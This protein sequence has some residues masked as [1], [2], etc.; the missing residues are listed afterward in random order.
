MHFP[1][2]LLALLI[3]AASAFGQ[4]ARVIAADS[5]K[6]LPLDSLRADTTRPDTLHAKKQEGVD[7]LVNYSADE[8]DFGVQQRVT[9]LK[10]SAV[11]T[12]KDMRLEA[13]QITVDWNKQIL[14]AVGIPDTIWTDS[15][16]TQ[17]D[18]IQTAGHPHFVQ[19]TED[20]FGDEIAYNMKSKLGRVR[21]GTTQYEQGYYYGRQFN[22]LPDNV[23]TVN[24][25]DFTTCSLNP[26]HYHFWAKE[27]KVMVG[28]R[29]IA[30]PVVLYFG[31]VP[32]LAVPYG[33][34]PQ[35]HGRTS[36]ILVPTFGES[37]A[38]GRFLKNIGYYWV[39]SDYMD[40]RGSVDYYE[41]LGLLGRGTY[42]YNKRFALDGEMDFD[43]NTQRQPSS[44]RHRDYSVRARHNQI[45]DRYTRLSVA[46][47]Y[48]SSRAYRQAIGTQQDV[49]NQQLESNATLSRS[50]EYWPW[51]LNAN[52]GYTQYLNLRTWSAVLPGISFTHKNGLLFPGPKAPRNIRGAVAPKE[53]NPPWY[54]AFSW[55]YG[56]IYRNEL[57]L[58]RQQ[59]EVGYRLGLIGLNGRQQSNTQILGVDTLNRFQ[60]DGAVHTGSIAAQARILRY[61]NLTPRLNL[62]A[63][64]TRGTVRYVPW[65]R[66]LVR[67][68][69][70]GF[71]QRTT[72]DLGSSATT[73]LY[74]L[75]ERPF[76]LD[77]SFRHVATPTVGLAWHP[78]FSDRQWGYFKKITL[79][80][81]RSLTYDRFPAGENISGAGGTPAGL[82]ERMNFGLDNLFQMKMGD[83]TMGGKETKFD[84]LSWTLGTGIDF[85]RD[86]LKWDNLGTSF[87]TTIPGKIVGPLQALSLDL[88]T[89]HSLYQPVRT[90]QGSVYRINR[91]YWQRPGAKWYAP[92]DLTNADVN[93]A[94][95]LRADKLGSLF[96]YGKGAKKDTTAVPDSLVVP[97]GN[98]SPP[99]FSQSAFPTP[100]PGG[101]EPAEPA[102]Q[103]A[104][105][106]LFDMPLTVSVNL[107][108]SHDYVYR[109]VTSGFGARASYSL[110]PKWDMSMD[111]SFDL[112]RKRVNNVGIYVT[113]D[114]H[115]WEMAFQW[116]P[117]GY[118][119]GY[120]FRLGLKS[121]ML[122]D[123]KVERHRESGSGVIYGQ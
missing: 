2:T 4:E 104:P 116:F 21:G 40:V 32:V 41:N 103:K 48:A 36:G 73:K 120:F 69:E 70:N 30:R 121:P 91:F 111:Y 86:S 33:I 42:L 61:L 93:V 50:W 1:L 58:S 76:G 64:T 37:S 56:V 62:R 60:H 31:D 7:T 122:H 68:D 18:T 82:S 63:L 16:N 51:T 65:D 27:L 72:F 94:F 38:E 9:V 59:K 100:P 99:D 22:R 108:Q 46:G 105:A 74:G 90:S 123:V 77:A 13:G 83:S 11:V 95:S 19:G 78:D 80:D 92:L 118:R 107:H 85:K 101:P 102:T 55:N 98:A 5:T 10:G 84:L 97:F 113:R 53:L 17:V 87:R 20:F 12:Y 49:L 119:P 44:G 8:I 25:G 110:T 106:E 6:R 81:G 35:Q 67:D 47:S 109:S 26:P 89:Q 115:C 114:L 45:L 54:R 39:M 34:F 117:L 88:T 24:K 52:V 112:H 75:L 57:S 15:T 29:V 23:I 66:I 96:S 3:L 71:F 79:P 43:F 14:T 28:K